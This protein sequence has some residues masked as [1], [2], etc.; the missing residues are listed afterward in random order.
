M[1]DKDVEAGTESRG[2]RRQRTRYRRPRNVR[3]LPTRASRAGGTEELKKEENLDSSEHDR[4]LALERA[5][6]NPKSC[7]K[8]YQPTSST[9]IEFTVSAIVATSG[10]VT[11]GSAAGPGLPYAA[12]KCLKERVESLTLQGLRLTSPAL[13][14]ATYSYKWDV[15]RVEVVTPVTGIARYMPKE[16]PRLQKGQSEISDSAGKE[17]SPDRGDDIRGPEGDDI[18]PDRGKD[19]G[20]GKSKWISG[21]T[22]KPIGGT[23]YPE[24]P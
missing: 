20:G 11:R 6:G 24:N 17:I 13:A 5:L 19:I 16:S 9:K 3:E 23:D 14:K 10:R 12:G 18:T 8:D 21:P 7:L 15:E 2:V 22:G 1:P 4:T